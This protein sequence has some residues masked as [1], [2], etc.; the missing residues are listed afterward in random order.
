[1]ATRAAALMMPSIVQISQALFCVATTAREPAPFLLFPVGNLAIKRLHGAHGI[2]QTKKTD[3][4]GPIH[5][6]SLQM[7][8][9]MRHN[10]RHGTVGHIND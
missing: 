4:S 2:R 3:L 1:L 6:T 8:L 7:A 5:A 9:S 10:D